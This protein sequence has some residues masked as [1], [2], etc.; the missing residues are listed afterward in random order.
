MIHT[1]PNVQQS[2]THLPTFLFYIICL[3]LNINIKKK[4]NNNSVLFND[5]ILITLLTHKNC[6]LVMLL[7]LFNKNLGTNRV[8]FNFLAYIMLNKTILKLGL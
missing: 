7:F 2:G 8:Q 1:T 5:K 6:Y 3:L 4:N